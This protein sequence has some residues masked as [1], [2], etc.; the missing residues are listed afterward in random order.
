MPIKKPVNNDNKIADVIDFLPN[1]LTAV[2]GPGMTIEKL[3]ALTNSET[4]T[5]GL[6]PPFPKSSTIGGVAMADKSGPMQLKWGRSRDRFMK[7]KVVLGDGRSNTYGAL[8][9]KN[10]TGY[11]VLRLLSGSWGS[12]AVVTELAVRLYKEPECT[13]ACIAGFE[14]VNDALKDSEEEYNTLESKR[15]GLEPKIDKKFLSL[16]NRM[17]NGRRGIGIISVHKNACGSCYNVLP[18]Q[19]V[20]EIRNAQKVIT[21]HTCGIILFWENED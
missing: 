9:V 13:G 3:N 14:N 17:K 18:P 15:G 4:Q 5:S 19:T 7:M 8:V 11:D 6:D 2:V 12:L 16:Y 1:D 21:C 20:I 10:V